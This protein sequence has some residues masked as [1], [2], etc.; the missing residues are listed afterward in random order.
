M[1]IINDQSENVVDA[2]DRNAPMANNN[3]AGKA[4]HPT[5]SP[6]HHVP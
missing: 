4:A 3:V 5:Q 1:D 2:Q 6:H